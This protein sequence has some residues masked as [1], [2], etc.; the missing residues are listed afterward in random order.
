M[1]MFSNSKNGTRTNYS[2]RRWFFTTKHWNAEPAQ[3][4]ARK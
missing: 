1:M 3:T 4:E 2:G